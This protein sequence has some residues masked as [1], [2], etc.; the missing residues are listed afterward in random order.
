MS[1]QPAWYWAAL[2]TGG[3]FFA[4]A[5]CNS[6]Q[7]EKLAPVS[8]KVTVE[9]QPLPAGSVCFRPDGSQGNASPHQPTG[10]IDTEGN[11]ELFVPPERKGAPPGWYKVVVIA[12]DNPRPGRLKSF[13]AAKYADEKT[14]PLKIEVIENP[15]SGRY[16]L[17]LTR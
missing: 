3:A 8:G 2:L 7:G 5:G 12:Y 6:G 14:T 1:R 16:D 17:K 13:I 9:G 11:Y 4:A 15:E 10:A